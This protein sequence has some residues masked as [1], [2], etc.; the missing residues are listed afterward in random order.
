M[1]IIHRNPLCTERVSFDYIRSGFKI[2]TMN[3]SYHIG[4][5]DR[6]QIVI[7]F[8]HSGQKGKALSSEIFLFQAIRL[9]H[10]AHGTIQYK[11]PLAY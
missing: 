3:F 6:Q 5:C 7:A 8:L 10:C 2:A 4:A 9:D 11:N 1:V